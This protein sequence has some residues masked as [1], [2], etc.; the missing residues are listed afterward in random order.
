[1]PTVIGLESACADGAV[2]AAIAA[3]VA[4][5]L[6][7][8]VFQ[9]VCDDQAVDW[10]VNVWRAN[11][12]LSPPTLPF[13]ERSRTIYVCV[14]SQVYQNTERYANHLV[15]IFCRTPERVE[16]HLA[17]RPRKRGGDCY[18]RP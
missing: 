13:L 18:R 2:N 6:R 3:I 1:M 15:Y 12:L 7:I 11:F 10:E 5:V 4:S 16:Y 9:I 8:L 14:T 17:G